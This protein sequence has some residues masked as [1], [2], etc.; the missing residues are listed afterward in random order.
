MFRSA[1]SR[2]NRYVESPTLLPPKLS[3]VGHQSFTSRE[4]ESLADLLCESTWP[5][6]TLNIYGLEGYLT[7]LLVWPVALHPGAWLP[8]IWN[9]ESWRVRPPIDTAQRYGEFVELTVGFLRTIDQGLLQSPPVFEPCLRWKLGDEALDIGARAE[10]W[11]QAFGRGLRQGIE[12]RVAPAQGVREAVHQ[13]A[14]Y[15]A[16]RSCFSRSGMQQAEIVLRKAVLA[17]ASTRI[18]RG[19]LGALPKHVATARTTS[20][21]S[22]HSVASVKAASP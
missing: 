16:G 7:A 19:P 4:R 9:E 10:H 11:A 15:A 8:P 5:R 2:S 3:E 14:T 18:S 13:V 12:A 1:R 22:Q 17:L 21:T 20:Q 6:D